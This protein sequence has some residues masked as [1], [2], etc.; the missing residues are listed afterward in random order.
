M[1]FKF[2]REAGAGTKTFETDTEVA[3]LNPKLE[4][5]GCSTC[6]EDIV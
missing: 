5:T 6:D 2:Q 4:P 1:K 3:L